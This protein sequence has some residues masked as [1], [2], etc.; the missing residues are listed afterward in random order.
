MQTTVFFEKL[1]EIV[2]TL[3]TGELEAFVSRVLT[4]PNQTTQHG[5]MKNFS[6]LIFG[7]RSKLDQLALEG[8]NK[9]LIDMLQLRAVFD[10]QRLADMIA[11]LSAAPNTEAIRNTPASYRLFFG[12]QALLAN[13]GTFRESLSKLVIEPRRADIG[14]GE[15]TLS[16]EILDLTGKGIVFDRL[17]SILTTI[18]S[19]HNI[20]AHAVGT[21]T[22][23]SVAYLDSGSNSLIA[24][25]SDGKSIGEFRK[26]LLGVWDR[27]RFRKYV[28][29]E[30]KIE[31]V[32]QGLDL[33]AKIDAQERSG[34][35][36]RNTAEQFKHVAIRDSL[37][38]FG[39][40]ATLKEIESDTTIDNR[41]L[42][43]DNIDTKLLPERTEVEG[44]AGASP[45]ASV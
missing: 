7:A 18:G 41:A 36:D 2:S 39:Q 34:T 12:F 19:L 16:F 45:D 3:G 4:G 5:L 26:L 8:D 42:L 10:D 44:D 15:E 23:L 17:Q 30:K 33:I 29:Y 14:P 1:S 9:L 6:T 20:I 13:L 37:A 31:A 32:G 11:A 38:L 21:E 35:L 40:G 22:T 25:K 24:V 28:D 27:I 43:L